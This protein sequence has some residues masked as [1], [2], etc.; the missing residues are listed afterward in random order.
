MNLTAF[1]CDTGID[2][3][4]RGIRTCER[5]AGAI[6]LL[7]NDWLFGLIGAS[8]WG[9]EAA[10]GRF[11]PVVV[12]HRVPLGYFQTKQSSALGFQLAAGRIAEVGPNTYWGMSSNP[13]DQIPP[14][15]PTGSTRSGTT[16]I[17]FASNA[18]ATSALL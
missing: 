13:G 14:P 4:R 15:A 1:Q 5:I 8:L 18:T 7:R 17:A 2:W 3:L 12:R 16:A 9:L 11:E 6:L 10:L